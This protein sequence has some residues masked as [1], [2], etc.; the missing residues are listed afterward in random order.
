[1][2]G[3]LDLTSHAL[4]T[5]TLQTGDACVFPA[6]ADYALKPDSSCELIEVALAQ[7]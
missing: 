3:S 2:H 6:G 4:G 7:G 1:L 5:H